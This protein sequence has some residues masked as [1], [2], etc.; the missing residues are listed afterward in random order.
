MVRESPVPVLVVR[1]EGNEPYT[2]AFAA[3]DLSSHRP[4]VAELARRGAPAVRL[5][6]G[7]V[8][9][10]PSAGNLQLAGTDEC[11]MLVLPTSMEPKR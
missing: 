5:T 9:G 6:L 3:L 7:H 2:R 11:E 8:F 4:A 1:R 10:G